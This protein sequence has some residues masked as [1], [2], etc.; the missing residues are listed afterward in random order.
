M[1]DEL[2]TIENEKSYWKDRLTRATK[3]V[4]QKKR[5]KKRRMEPVVKTKFTKKNQEY[6]HNGSLL[7]DVGMLSLNHNSLDKTTKSSKIRS[8]SEA[9]DCWD[10]PGASGVSS[11]HKRFSKLR[12][13]TIY[14][15]GGYEPNL[16]A[17]IGERKSKLNQRN[18]FAKSIQRDD[19]RV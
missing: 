11:F 19:S 6:A 2:Q 16:S 7:M 4:L 9:G 1:Y 3:E 5:K 13:K 18:P 17:S 10:K 12:S 8:L 14:G 15:S